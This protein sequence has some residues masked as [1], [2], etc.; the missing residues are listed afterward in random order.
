M[1]VLQEYLCCRNNRNRMKVQRDRCN[2]SVKWRRVLWNSS[3]QEAER[4]HVNS[5]AANVKKV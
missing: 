2:V 3:G 4:N 1:C 5:V